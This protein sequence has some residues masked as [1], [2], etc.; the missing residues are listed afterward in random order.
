[1]DK[2]NWQWF[3]ELIKARYQHDSL[4]ETKPNYLE[5]NAGEHPR[6]PFEGHEFLRF[7]SK[8]SGSHA[9]GVEKYLDT[10]TEIAQ[11]NFGSRIKY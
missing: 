4:V 7:S 6:L 8:V 11:A 2:Q 1:M 5:F 9:K 10:V 3:I